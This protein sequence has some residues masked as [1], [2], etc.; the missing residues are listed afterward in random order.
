MT[1]ETGLNSL[2][3][4]AAACTAT[5]GLLACALALSTALAAAQDAEKKPEPTQPGFFD[6][7][8]RWFTQ[9][10][11]NFNSGVR[12]MRD[13]FQN[14]G[15]AAGD[16]AKSTVETA[17]N[18]AESVGRLSTTRVV[19]GHQKCQDAPN[20][21]PD[22]V[23]AADTICKAKGFKSG[24]SVDMTTAEVCPA[25]VYLSGQDSGPGCHTITFVSRALC[26]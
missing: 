5:A 9:S 19:S 8:T 25:Q 4:R 10:E 20:G 22:C 11:D 23:A 16:A 7:I 21:A 12:T 26:Q 18:A 17:R 3:R 2:A 6:S 13:R 24:K 14:F 15:S 1:L